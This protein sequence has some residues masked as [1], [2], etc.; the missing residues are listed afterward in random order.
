MILGSLPG[1]E[2]RRPGFF[3]VVMTVPEDVDFDI[4]T[5]QWLLQRG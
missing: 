4:M 2:A 3:R 1:S 5:H